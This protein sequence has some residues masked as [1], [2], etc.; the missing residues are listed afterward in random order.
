MPGCA[1]LAAIRCV[2]GVT[3]F[4]CWTAD[5]STLVGAQEAP[6][7]KK[8][9][10]L[11]GK[12]GRMRRRKEQTAARTAVRENMEAA[13]DAAVLNGWQRRIPPGD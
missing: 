2:D 8:Y 1:A 5:G 7:P 13:A 3:P 6:H 12:D 4:C 9:P 10:F 11:A